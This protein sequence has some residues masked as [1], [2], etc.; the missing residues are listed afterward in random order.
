MLPFNDY[1][2]VAVKVVEEIEQGLAELLVA[3]FEIL[4]NTKLAYDPY[5]EEMD[6]QNNV[7]RDILLARYVLPGFAKDYLMSGFHHFV[8]AGVLAAQLAE[9]AG[10]DYNEICT[11]YLTGTV[12]DYEKTYPE[13]VSLDDE[14]KLE[15]FSSHLEAVCSD[16]LGNV[17][18]RIASRALQ[19][20]R[21]LESGGTL[22]KNKLIA[23]IV[24]IS[25]YLLS[26]KEAYDAMK[27]IEL[28]IMYLE[29]YRLGEKIL[30]L[31]PV[32]VGKHRL[33][34]FYVSEKFVE[35][36]VSVAEPLLLTPTGMVVV[37][38]ENLDQ[39]IIREIA[40][41]LAEELVASRMGAKGVN[42]TRR[43]EELIK[44]ILNTGAKI[45][46]KIKAGKNIAGQQ[47][48]SV[49]T[50]FIDVVDEIEIRA[51]QNLYKLPDLQA[52]IASLV[53]AI[54][55]E[56]VPTD[57]KKSIP[58]IASALQVSLKKIKGPRWN[59]LLAP[60]I[61][62]RASTQEQAL[63][64]LREVADLARR[65]RGAKASEAETYAS[66]FE[67]EL[68]SMI[69]LPVEVQ[70]HKEITQKML[71]HCITCRAELVEGEEL[72]FK[73][74][75]DALK[76]RVSR[77][78]S[79]EVFHPDV[80]GVLRGAKAKDAIENLKKLPVCPAC[81]LEASLLPEYG[82]MGASWVAVMSYAP[83]LPYQLLQSIRKVLQWIQNRE[84]IKF[85]VDYLSAKIVIA[86]ARGK[87]GLTKGWLQQVLRYWYLLGGSLA[88][89][90]NPLHT[91]DPL[92]CP[93]HI[94]RPDAFFEAINMYILERLKEAKRQRRYV[95]QRIYRLRFEAYRLMQLYLEA[96]DEK[97][98]GEIRFMPTLRLP[99]LSPLLTAISLYVHSKERR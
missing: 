92:E 32:L 64:L 54:G 10:L 33:L 71:K 26:R 34:S 19:I 58:Y 69:R 49:S 52:L 13:L 7:N 72:S 60:L 17:A 6:E 95:K 76:K 55:K 12:H 88:T 68:A 78:I 73:E 74:Y 44:E 46:D 42:I 70:S 67:K 61:L 2:V 50:E 22:G 86:S 63:E 62:E 91:P 28:L 98:S 36:A 94:A 59:D 11:A 23:N 80:Q 18:S 57:P 90:R 87:Q 43:K 81:M 56:R 9:L 24:R 3:E 65:V 85:L 97:D 99:P 75:A 4:A 21:T 96:V 53:I 45:V 38:R 89:T 41:G 20:A 31:E 93:I 16:A 66:F 82:V 5:D 35:K 37:L 14:E 48:K 77:N 79:Q 84:Q 15:L 83:V 39:S 29:R 8:G 30:N 1:L 27:A 47:I 40:K 25:D 51:L